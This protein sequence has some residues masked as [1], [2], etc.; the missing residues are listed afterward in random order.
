MKNN[1]IIL[2]LFFLYNQLTVTTP[3][4]SHYTVIDKFG[5]FLFAVKKKFYINGNYKD[6]HSLSA[7]RRKKKKE[8]SIQATGPKLQIKMPFCAS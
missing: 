8:T 7:K 1:W 3:H 2:L 6:V 4:L 5:A